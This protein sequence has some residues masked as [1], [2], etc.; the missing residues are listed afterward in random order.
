MFIP[1]G[2]FSPSNDPNFQP[3]AECYCYGK[4]VSIETLTNEFSGLEFRH[5][6]MDTCAAKY[7]VLVDFSYANKIEV[8]DIVGGPFWINAKV[9]F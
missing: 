5:M 3:H 4:V 7:D 8:G 1:S 9:L 2:T 6:I